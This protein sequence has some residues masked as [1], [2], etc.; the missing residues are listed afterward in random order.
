ME[1]T[2]EKNIP[3]PKRARTAKYPFADMQV[4]DSF[5]IEVAFEEMLP[6]VMRRMTSAKTISAA[7]LRKQRGDDT[8]FIVAEVPE[9]VRVWRK[10]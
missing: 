3:L 4:G 8:A 5:L 7:Q 1:Y 6:K 10:E 9:G 2:I